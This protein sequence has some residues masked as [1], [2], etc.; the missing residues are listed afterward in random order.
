MAGGWGIYPE[1]FIG[2]QLPLI[3]LKLDVSCD[4][5]VTRIHWVRFILACSVHHF[6]FLN[7]L[8]PGFYGSSPPS[9]VRPLWLLL[10]FLP[11][12]LFLFPLCGWSP[13]FYSGLPHFYPL[14]LGKPFCE[15][16]STVTV[17]MT[18]APMS[19]PPAL[20]PESC[21]HIALYPH[22]TYLWSCLNMPTVAIG[23]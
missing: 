5:L 18:P 22:S 2:C 11:R 23:Q 7:S 20:P 3:L 21:R 9:L 10:G 6:L 8:Y 4:F 1:T 16:V 19:M 13:G 12:L 14:L 15:M 17:V